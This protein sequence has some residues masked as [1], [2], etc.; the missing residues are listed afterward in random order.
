MRVEILR[1]CNTSRGYALPGPNKPEFSDIE[2]QRLID[3]GH[4]KEWVDPGIEEPEPTPA[5]PAAHA[6]SATG[7]EENRRMFD[8]ED[9]PPAT[10]VP[11]AQSKKKPAPAKKRTAKKKRATAKKRPAAQKAKA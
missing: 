3:D 4:A 9:D 8:G 11:Q 10:D 1:E 5:E 7:L 2:A 6:E